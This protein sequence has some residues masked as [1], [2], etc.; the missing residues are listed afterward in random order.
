MDMDF[1]YESGGRKDV[2]IAGPPK[3]V[4]QHWDLKLDV[5]TQLQGPGPGL[6]SLSTSPS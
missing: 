5:P 3:N 4:G 2:A 6:P 1:G